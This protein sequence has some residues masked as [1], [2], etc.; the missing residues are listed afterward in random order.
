MKSVGIITIHRIFNFGSIL[1]AYALYRVIEDLG[2]DVEI[3]DYRFPNSFQVSKNI[4]SKRRL[5]CASC[6][7]K[8][9]LLKCCYALALLKQHHKML[10]AIKKMLKTSSVVYSTPEA[11]TKIAEK[12]D[13]FVTG[14]DQ[15]WNPRYT[16]GDPSFLLYFASDSKRKIAY[17]ASFGVSEIKDEYKAVYKEL[18]LRYDVISVREKSGVDLVGQLTDGIKIATTVLDPTLLLTYKQWNELIPSERLIKERYVLCYFL[19]YTFN[20]FPYADD[21]AEHVHNI[22]GYR[23]VR[24]GRPPMKFLNTGQK[25]YVNAGPYEMMQLVRDAELV[26][27]TSFHGTAFAVNFGV[28]VYSI[29]KDR[30]GNDSRQLNLL[31][32]VQLDNRI[33]ALGDK[34]PKLKDLKYD[35]SM[36]ILLLDRARKHSLSFLKDSLNG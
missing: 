8:Q 36:S 34:F 14:S 15:V 4:S 16:K 29:I 12:Y 10:V 26:L 19:N 27:T 1:Q 22:T 18:L 21:L 5:I 9:K 23:V 30:M 2:Y 7:I 25:F 32:L 13:I 31:K 20:A 17:A 28:P 24:L 3:I 33:I 35:A 6:G 11:L